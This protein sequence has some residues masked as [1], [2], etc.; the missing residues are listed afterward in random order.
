MQQHCKIEC[1]VDVLYIICSY[2]V[3][4]VTDE[5]KTKNSF[6]EKLKFDVHLFLDVSIWNLF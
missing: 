2:R 6:L 1:I 3:K 4:N 5:G